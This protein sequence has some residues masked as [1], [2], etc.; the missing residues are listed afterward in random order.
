MNPLPR[1][2][3]PVEQQICHLVL[4]NNQVYEPGYTAVFW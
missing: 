3:K 2:K 1:L 4:D